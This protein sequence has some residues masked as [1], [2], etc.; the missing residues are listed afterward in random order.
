[1][2]GKLFPFI[3]VLDLFPMANI[4][5]TAK[6]RDW[7]N[8]GMDCCHQKAMIA[9]DSSGDLLVYHVVD[10]GEEF[11]PETEDKKR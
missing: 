6:P 5:F 8:F 1:M 7:V 11:A 2:I 3:H 9:G 4:A 10:Q